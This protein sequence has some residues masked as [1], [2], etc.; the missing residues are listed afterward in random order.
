M[1]DGYNAPKAVRSGASTGRAG[2]VFTVFQTLG[3]QQHCDPEVLEPKRKCHS[4]L[5]PRA[6]QMGQAEGVPVDYGLAADY[7][8]EAVIYA[9]HILATSRTRRSPC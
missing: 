1:D 7:H 6:P 2:K 5:W 4:S 9:K 3:T 8:T